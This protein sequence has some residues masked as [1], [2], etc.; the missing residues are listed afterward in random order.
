[1]KGTRT[2]VQRATAMIEDIIEGRLHVIGDVSSTMR[3]A[4]ESHK[5]LMGRKRRRIQDL[6]AKHN[7]FLE[8]DSSTLRIEGREEDVDRA[9]QAL[10]DS[11][12]VSQDKDKGSKGQAGR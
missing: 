8:I 5:D 4:A 2:S 3:I 12:E 1:M 11:D 6:S 9:R 10:A 7:V